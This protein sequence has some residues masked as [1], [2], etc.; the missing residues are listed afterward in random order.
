MSDT[1]V[2]PEALITIG[3]PC[4]AI[5][6]EDENWHRVTITGIASIDFVEVYLSSFVKSNLLCMGTCS[7]TIID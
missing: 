6:P 4:A 5:F 3:Q 7:F 1:Y 2:M